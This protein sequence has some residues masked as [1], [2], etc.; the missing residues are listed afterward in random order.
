M[1]CLYLRYC[2]KFRKIQEYAFWLLLPIFLC[3]YLLHIL[4][5]RRRNFGHKF[6]A[7][8]LF[9]AGAIYTVDSQDL[10]SAYKR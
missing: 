2:T 5:E 10:I 3:G 6:I 9:V 7:L 1:L 8:Y 4:V